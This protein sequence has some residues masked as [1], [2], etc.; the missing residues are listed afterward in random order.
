MNREGLPWEP[1]ESWANTII[2]DIALPWL[3][4]IITHQQL[5]KPYFLKKDTVKR[6]NPLRSMRLQ[7]L[8]RKNEKHRYVPTVSKRTLKETKQVFITGG[9]G[10][11]GVHLIQSLLETGVEK[12]HCL[13]RE[14][15]ETHFNETLSN[16]FGPDWLTENQA[17][18]LLINGDISKKKL[19]I[20]KADYDNIINSVDKIYHC[21]ADVR[22]YADVNESMTI[23][24]T[25]TENVIELALKANAALHHISTTSVAADYVRSEADR[26]MQFFEM[27]FD[28]GQNWK[29]N[30]YVRTK[31][32]AEDAV[33]RAIEQGLDARV[34]RVGR[35]VGRAIDGK[36]QEN[37]ES[38][39]F[40]LL[41]RAIRL[42]QA[43]PASMAGRS[44]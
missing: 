20:K 44:S 38:N 12:I 3:T 21:A 7:R 16:F 27:D 5:N 40:F 37:P 10:Y 23:N 39:A 25:G 6:Y 31:F 18:L 30:V 35:L 28:I 15:R 33:Y 11:L 13:V 2:W 14:G 32:L 41:I 42:S 1:W 29:D 4:F 34:Y 26:N 43:I 22:H 24:L 8:N 17:K 36:F 9:G 19:G